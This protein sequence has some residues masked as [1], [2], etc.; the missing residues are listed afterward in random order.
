MSLGPFNPKIRFLGQKVC[1]V[2]HAQT[3][4][5]TRRHTPTDTQWIL[6]TPFQGFRIFFLQPIIKDQCNNSE[7][8]PK[9]LILPWI[10]N[11]VFVLRFKNICFISR[12]MC[13]FYKSLSLTLQYSNI[14]VPTH[15]PRWSWPCT[16]V[17]WGL[18]PRSRWRPSSV[19]K[20]SFSCTG[21]TGSFSAPVSAVW[22]RH[23]GLKSVP[24][25]VRYFR[26]R[27]SLEYPA[28]SLLH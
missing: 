17:N 12:N 5:H 14:C 28:C 11:F 10:T 1:P 18:S 23:W 25:L 19:R 3:D 27:L 20:V 26:F 16:L 7:V 6:M 4:R 9:L 24:L 8:Y 15:S 21:V 13:I 22:L 2:V